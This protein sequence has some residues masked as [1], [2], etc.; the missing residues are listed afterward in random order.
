MLNLGIIGA[1]GSVGSSV[2]AVCRAH[3]DKIKIKA[4]AA[5]K[6]SSK[7]KNLID[8]FNPDYFITY[9]NDGEKGL[10]K[11]ALDPEIDHLV[12]ASSGTGAIKSL[13][14]ALEANK[15][16]S[17]ANKESIVVAGK[18]VMPL[19]KRDDQLRPL[20]SEHNAIWQCLRGENK[21]FIRKIYLTASGGPF[22]EFNINELE[23][24]TPEM[25]LKH[26]V[27]NMGAKITIDSA[28]LM[29]KGIE[30]IEAMYL[31]NLNPEQ[32]SALISPGSFIHGLIEFSDGSV[33]LLGANPDMK[34]PASS[35]LFWPEKYLPDDK[36]KF[37][38]YENINIKFY[39][40]DYKKFPSI[41]I[42]REVMNS[43]GIYPAVL[44]GA[45][46][47]AVEKFLQGKIKFTQ[48][49]DLIKKVLDSC[50][51]PEPKNLDDAINAVEWAKN[52]A[53]N[54]Y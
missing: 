41:K 48:I 5:N 42:A 24:V 52:F 13:C 7:L 4:L 28:T 18:W 11:I 1:T 6:F 47:I 53:R 10:N 9:E 12:F 8:E 51:I 31:F 25:A 40:P 16:I 43:K 38:D 44:I 33:K 30:L 54:A 19:I 26:P 17:L 27:W 46:E 23:N 15:N 21:N 49:P 14:K 22:R 36:F 20:D 39:E 34:L 2:I 32:V 50:N 3:K 29:N 37:P 45:D 35:C